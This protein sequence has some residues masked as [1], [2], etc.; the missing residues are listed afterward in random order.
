MCAVDS[1]IKNKFLVIIN[2]FMKNDFEEFF[3]FVLSYQFHFNYFTKKYI[4]SRN[5]CYQSPLQLLRDW[6]L[7]QDFSLFKLK[8]TIESIKK[9]PFLTFDSSTEFFLSTKL[10]DSNHSRLQIKQNVTKYIYLHIEYATQ[11]YR[12][13]RIL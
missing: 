12:S 3:R 1:I 5:K 2:S 6:K 10:I 9:H 13:M 8:I 11:N 7:N 4:F